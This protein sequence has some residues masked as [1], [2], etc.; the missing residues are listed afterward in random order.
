MVTSV[1]KL[2]ERA[3]RL[4]IN[5][6]LAAKS[7]S[8]DPNSAVVFALIRGGNERMSWPSW[9]RASGEKA[10]RKEDARHPGFSS[11]ILVLAATQGRA[12][13]QTAACMVA[14]NYRAGAR[15]TPPTRKAATATCNRSACSSGDCAAVPL[16]S[17]SVVLCSVLLFICAT[18]RVT[19]QCGFLA[20]RRQRRFSIR[21]ALPPQCRHRN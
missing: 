20:R 3:Q 4:R 1:C 12:A 8:R 5:G 9:L 16:W 19:C 10:A 11:A 14:S 13:T 2:T 7:P 17:T 18:A 15:A 6:C 21:C